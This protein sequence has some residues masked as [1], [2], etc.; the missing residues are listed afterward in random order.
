[1]PEITEDIHHEAG[2]AKRVEEQ[3]VTETA[4]SQGWT[5]HGDVIL[6]SPVIYRVLMINLLPQPVDN[7]ARG[8]H[9]AS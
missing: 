2:M 8:P 1:M 7:L 4:V 5:E 9:T 3:H 6:V